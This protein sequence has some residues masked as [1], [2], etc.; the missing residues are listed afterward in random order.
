MAQLAL[1]IIF[2]LFAVIP[3]A[4]LLRSTAV[5]LP[6]ACVVP[7][8]QTVRI[9]I[10]MSGTSE[11]GDAKDLNW[12]TLLISKGAVDELPEGPSGFDVLEDGSIVIVDPLR[13]R[14][15]VF[16]P[17]GKFRKAWKTGFAADSV[18]LMKNGL[19][20][21]EESGTDRLH[22]YDRDGLARPQES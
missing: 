8:S 6:S 14:I 22:V 4:V 17:Q 21:V 12:P 15:C 3:G 11:Q 10:T 9:P 7:L 13:K 20:A 5:P 18:T 19:L 16:D 1:S 2:V